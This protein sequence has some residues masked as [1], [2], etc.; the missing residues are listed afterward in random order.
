VKYFGTDGIRGKFGGSHVNGEFFTKLAQVIGEFFSE[1]ISKKNLSV[2]MG[3]DT[4]SSGVELCDALCAGFPGETRVLNCGILPTPAIAEAT[5]FS[6]SDVGIAVTASHNPG[7]DNGIKIFN[8]RGEK[9]TVKDE[10]R[11]EQM[12]DHWQLR[13][14]SAVKV[15]DFHREAE[16]NYGDK[17]RNFPLAGALAG[18]IIVLDS[19]N[20]A[21]HAVAKKIFSDLG[22]CVMQ[23][24][25]SPDGEN[26]NENCGSEHPENLAAITKKNGA[27]AGIANDGDGDRAVIFDENGDRVDGDVLM[28]TIAVHMARRG[29]L[30]NGKIVATIQSNLGLDKYLESVGIGVI[31]CDVG[32]RN[33]YQG[34][35]ENDCY[36]GGENSGHLIFRKFSPI[37]DGI[38]AA[39]YALL[40]VVEKNARLSKLKTNIA[41]FP[42]KSFNVSVSERIPLE[43]IRGLGDDIERERAKLPTPGRIV[44]RY[45]GTEPKLRV[46]VEAGSEKSVDHAWGNLQK[47][48][49]DR[50]NENDISAHIS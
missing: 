23:I 40:L 39:L 13:R 27:F 37:G 9:L 24:G 11:I 47:S 21:T 3:R 8:G 46:F 41:L 50:M 17:F 7:S 15:V 16:A 10:M 43:K 42:Q 19:A 32:D 22:I 5:I 14:T 6:D 26:I 49:L 44:A 2:C 20:G 29:E 28:G 45:S 18:K 34:M 31:R 25:C 35:L 4:R 12:L 36:F 48:I 33:V 1:K 30:P 38:T